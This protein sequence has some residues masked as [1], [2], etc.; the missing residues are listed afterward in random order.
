MKVIIWGHK[1][2]SG[3]NIGG[4]KLNSHT[5]SYIH[6]GYFKAFSHLGYETFWFDNNNDVSGFDFSNCLF[7]TEAQVDQKIPLIEGCVYVLHHCNNEK[8]SLNKCKILNLCNY[9]ADCERGVSFNYE[10]KSVERVGELQF[11]DKSSKAFYQPWATDLLPHEIDITNVSVFDESRKDVNYIGTVNHDNIK[12]RIREFG[13]ACRH[14]KKRFNVYKNISYEDNIK[15]IRDSYVS[16]DI[17]GDWH[18]L[19]G[20]IPCRIWKNISYG[21]FVGTNSKHIFTIFGKMVA[22]HE[23]PED[24]F[25]VCEEKYRALKKSEFQNTMKFVRDNHTYVNRVKSL[26][27]MV[28]ECCG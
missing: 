21:K 23:R 6:Y 10:G 19:R 15:L 8:Y 11:Y 13:K 5:H 24:L 26:L 3:R 16:V 12:P 22:F 9:V 7:L 25:R 2:V 20:Y 27:R 4:R 28:K 18:L 14:N 17:R 1:P